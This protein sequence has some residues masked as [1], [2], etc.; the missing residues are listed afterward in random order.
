MAELKDLEGELDR[1]RLRLLVAA[2]FVL[3]GFGLLAARLTYLQVTRYEDLAEQAETN[4][5]AVI[6]IVPNRGQIVD[7][8]GTVLATNYSAYTLEIM[9]SKVDDLEAT[10][11]ELAGFIDIGQAL[12][13]ITCQRFGLG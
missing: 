6:P 10:I 9:P 1:F 3:L 2:A 11:D 8:N 12:Q 4:R 5:T 13:Q 7:R